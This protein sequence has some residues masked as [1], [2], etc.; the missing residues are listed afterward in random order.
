M[1]KRRESRQGKE[2]TIV[3]RIGDASRRP[4]RNDASWTGVKPWGEEEAVWCVWGVYA[5]TTC[6]VIIRKH[7]WQV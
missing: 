5:N 2:G 6:S 7:A 3:E 1:E 4:S